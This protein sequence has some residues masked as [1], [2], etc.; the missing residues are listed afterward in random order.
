MLKLLLSDDAKRAKKIIK[1]FKP[2]F[3]SKEEFLAFQDS[4]NTSG[5]RIVYRDDGV[6]EVKLENQKK[7][8]DTQII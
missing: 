8:E 6:A 7:D 1:E 5:D 4:L 3:A 2:Q